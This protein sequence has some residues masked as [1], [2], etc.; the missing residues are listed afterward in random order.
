MTLQ[1]S[2]SVRNG[3][4]NAIPTAIG[5]SAIL[6]FLTGAVEANCAAADSG[7]LVVS[8]SLPASY[9]AAAS[10]GAMALTGTWTGTCGNAGTIGHF[11]LKDNAG[12]TCHL[13]GTVTITGG[14]G[15]LTFDNNVLQLNQ[16]VNVIT[17]TLTE[18]GA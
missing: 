1:K 8:M 14:G 12:T 13:Q 16:I 18:S 10:A 6:R 15:D 17:F 3:Q 11:R 4:L 2:T 9:F 7:T 5:A